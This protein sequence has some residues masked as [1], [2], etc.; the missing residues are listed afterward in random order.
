MRKT[1]RNKEKLESEASVNIKGNVKNNTGES[2]GNKIG[3]MST[4]STKLQNN[5]NLDN[6]LNQF[7]SSS[8][9]KPFQKQTTTISNPKT[10]S[11]FPK[12]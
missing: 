4:T 5:T 12:T 10:A 3:V 7:L 6:K 1:M 2:W 9:S 8:S 11:Q